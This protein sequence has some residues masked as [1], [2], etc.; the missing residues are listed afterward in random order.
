VPERAA[1]L[2]RI[3]DEIDRRREDFLAAEMADTGKPHAMASS[4]DIPRGAAN[5]RAFA[6]LIKTAPL[7]SYRMELPGGAQALN[8]AVRKALGVVGIISPWNLP[9]LLLTW[10]VAPALAC[11]NAVVA[12]PSEETP[13]TATLLAEVMET[14]GVPAGAF[15]LVHGFGPRSAGEF[16]TTHTDIDAITFTGESSTGATIMRAAAEGVKP[17]SFE[18]GGKNAAIIFADCDFPKMLDGMMRAVFLNSGQVCLCAERVY[19][20]RALYERF[21]VAFTERVRSLKLGWPH[22]PDSAMGPLISAEHR[23]KVLQYFAL[24]R[25]EGA[26]FLAGGGV[27]SFGDARD[28]GFWVEPTLITGLPPAARCIKEEIFG[29]ICHI[30]PFDTE[31]QVI[32]QANDT[33]Y[34]LAASVWTSDLNRAHRVAQAMHVGLSWVNTWFL[35]DLRTPFG[36][37]GLSGIGREGGMHSLNF[38]SELTNVCV[39][40]D[41]SPS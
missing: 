33:R 28:R 25:E 4:I 12:K 24:A 26:Q 18:L 2:Y 40:I 27:P 20:E 23:D 13:G 16:I 8:Y 31:R 37:A 41:G 3:A 38:Y 39:H 29:P 7:E 34:G 14:V 17:V 11:G 5:F 15:N 22:E 35:R 32:K 36:G 6:D 19:V 21:C 9:L 1:L 10:K 30:A